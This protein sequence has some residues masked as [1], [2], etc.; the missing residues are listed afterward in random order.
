[1]FADP[2]HWGSVL[3]ICSLGTQGLIVWLYHTFS[4][5]CVRIVSRNPFSVFSEASPSTCLRKGRSTSCAE[6]A[7]HFFISCKANLA[8]RLL[9]PAA[10]TAKVYSDVKAVD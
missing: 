3:H 1:M 10:M 8:T 9:I 6:K 5:S 7:A 2:Y 4:L